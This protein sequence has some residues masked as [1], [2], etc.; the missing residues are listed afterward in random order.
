MGDQIQG[1][2]KKGTCHES[3]EQLV[4]LGNPLSTSRKELH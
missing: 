2:R 3:L 1:L 4:F